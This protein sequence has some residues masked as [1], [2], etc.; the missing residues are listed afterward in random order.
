MP[1]TICIDAEF[2]QEIF[3]ISQSCIAFDV[4]GRFRRRWTHAFML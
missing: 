4:L 2:T 3:M 1:E